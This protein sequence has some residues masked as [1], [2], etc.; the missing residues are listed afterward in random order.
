MKLN[1]SRIFLVM[2]V[3]L[4]II[5]ACARETSN[6]QDSSSS[7]D[8]NGSA[9]ERGGDEY[10]NLDYLLCYLKFKSGQYKLQNRT[11]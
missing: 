6:D 2:A 1:T 3:S 4:L 11:V 10:V 8:D 5:S 9:E 7:L